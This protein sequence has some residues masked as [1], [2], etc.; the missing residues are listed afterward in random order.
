MM[1]L[2]EELCK[3]Q[4]LVLVGGVARKLNGMGH[5]PKDIDV[6]VTDLDG[7][8]FFGDIIEFDTDFVGSISGKRAYIKRFDY[9]IDI[10]IE[11]TLPDF[12]TDQYTRFETLDH[13][14]CH[15][16]NILSKTDGK[17]HDIIQQKYDDVYK[18]TSK[19]IL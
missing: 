6:V 18:F 13:M 11:D 9:M 7:M 8:D 19:D 2:L 5:N 4:N 10:F 3:K 1:Y 16:K 17:T 15:F 12:I 14:L